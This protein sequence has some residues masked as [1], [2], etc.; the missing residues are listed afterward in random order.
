[1]T[2]ITVTSV[3][4]VIIIMGPSLIISTVITYNIDIIVTC[5]QTG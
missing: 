1:M 5:A 2:V 3:N 4:D